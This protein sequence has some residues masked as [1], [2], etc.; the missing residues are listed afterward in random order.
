MIADSYK[1]GELSEQ[2]AET[3][4]YF[5]NNS[6]PS[7][8]IGAVGIGVFHSSPA[9]L[10]LYGV[11][12]LSA[13]ITGMFLSGTKSAPTAGSPVFIETAALSAVLP[14]AIGKAVTQ[15]LLVCGYVVFFGAVSGIL[16]AAD[17][18][19]ALCGSLA[20]YTPLT[21]HHARA[22][23]MGLLELGC[24]MGAMA[25]STLSPQSLT[26][27]AFLT[28]FGGLS[29]A[30]QTGGMLHGT[31]LPLRNHLLG[32]LCCGTISGFLMYSISAILL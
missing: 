13:I 29:V 27:C 4:L 10:L 18:L 20:L 16:E 25:G 30:L 22:L 21:L 23:C 14:D 17:I 11:H 6:G 2:E 12:I 31:G 8:L 32:R 9:G 19:S 28:G 1:S 7:F 26:L 3:L 5:C 24:G 15:T